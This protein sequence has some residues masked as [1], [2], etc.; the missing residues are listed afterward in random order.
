MKIEGLRNIARLVAL[1]AMGQATPEQEGEL[2]A[3]RGQSEGNDRLLAKMLSRPRL[4]RNIGQQ[5]RTPAEHRRQWRK[6]ECKIARAERGAARNTTR[7]WVAAAAAA[8]VV[9]TCG[10]WL[11]L[12][13][14]PAEGIVMLHNVP[15]LTLPDGR[16]VELNADAAAQAALRLDEQILSYNDQD[17]G[18]MSEI[19]EHTLAVPR[20]AEMSVRLSDGTLV[21]LNAASTLSYP[22]LFVGS[23]RR[24]RL[25]GEAFFEVA[26]DAV[27][28][29]FVETEGMEIQVT[30]TSF[31]VRAYADESAAHAVLVEGG[32]T[33]R[34]GGLQQQL[35]P[36]QEAF[37]DMRTGALTQRAANIAA[38]LSWCEGRFAYHGASLGQIFDD[39]S[40]WY[41]FEVEWSDP[42]L[43]ELRYEVDIRRHDDFNRI[44]EVLS[45][46]R[47]VGF[48]V[49][50]K[51]I[52]IKT[53]QT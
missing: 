29:F 12:E 1:H 51:V 37:F 52:R 48:D 23:Q 24:V 21:R 36:H 39:L 50:G 53:T 34:A 16:T 4:L 26:K 22:A 13:R 7:R 35:E 5:Y 49:Q 14:K 25:S 3:W 10:L 11:T 30:G 15:T 44:L 41:D 32:V 28:P 33:V 27:R 8:V 20:G 40:R 47:T 2:E 43:R 45:A 17:T 6:I 46:T 42:A 31:G 9:V 38:A 18:R 19:G